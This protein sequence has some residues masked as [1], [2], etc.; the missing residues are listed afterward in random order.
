MFFHLQYPVPLILN[1]PPVGFTV[2]AEKHLDPGEI[3]LS[4]TRVS[5]G[6]QQRLADLHVPFENRV[7][8]R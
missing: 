8:L 2:K 5:A 7:R 4:D 3:I 6:V 1:D